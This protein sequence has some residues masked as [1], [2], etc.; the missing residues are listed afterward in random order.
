MSTATTLHSSTLSDLD[1]RSVADMDQVGE[2]ESESR[3]NMR[4][5]GGE[6]SDKWEQTGQGRRERE[7]GWQISDWTARTVSRAQDGNAS[8]WQRDPHRTY[9]DD[10][11][12]GSQVWTAARADTAASTSGRTPA[13][14]QWRPLQDADPPTDRACRVVRV[15]N[16]HSSVEEADLRHALGPPGR[17]AEVFLD[18]AA[19]CAV[20]IPHRPDEAG[21]LAD[22]LRGRA[23]GPHGWRLQVEFDDRGSGGGGGGGGYMDESGRM[24]GAASTWV[25]RSEQRG[26]AGRREWH[27]VPAQGAAAAVA[28]GAS[29]DATAPPPALAAARMAA[30][31]AGLH[32]GVGAGAP[33][34]LAAVVEQAPAASFTVDG[35]VRP[36]PVAALA[37]SAVTNARMEAAAEMAAAAEAEEVL[38]ELESV[39]RRRGKLRQL[40]EAN[41]AELD[42]LLEQLAAAEEEA[43]RAQAT[44]GA[45]AGLVGREIVRVGL[46]AT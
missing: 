38:R 33:S 3:G 26:T 16:V 20:V 28:S 13:G 2:T 11:V 24:L 19:Q 9:P 35:S 46:S 17:D 7:Q 23:L 37:D 25:S 39:R 34:I 15:K 5:S 14:R 8:D 42:A 45:A 30:P 12:T 10:R 44:V 43:A 29:A 1:H 36:A 27:A 22:A 31:V 32:S 6:K 4:E 41:Q 21:V 18:R 40:S